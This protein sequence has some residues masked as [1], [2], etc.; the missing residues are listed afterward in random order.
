MIRVLHTVVKIHAND[1][2]AGVIMY[3]DD[4]GDIV[5]DT[6]DGEFLIDFDDFF[7]ALEHLGVME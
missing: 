7:R 2:D 4:E 6:G 1:D 5:I 3:R